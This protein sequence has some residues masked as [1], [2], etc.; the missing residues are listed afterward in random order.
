MCTSKYTL[1]S[2]PNYWNEFIIQNVLKK[3]KQ[4][5]INYSNTKLYL[6]FIPRLKCSASLNSLKMESINIYLYC[7]KYC[8]LHMLKLNYSF[9]AWQSNKIMHNIGRHN[10]N[11]VKSFSL[12]SNRINLSNH[13]VEHYKLY[14]ISKN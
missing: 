1:I 6:S 2:P 10:L 11:H 7:S 4:G 14:A 3:N 5:T 13:T 9:F 12:H 8:C